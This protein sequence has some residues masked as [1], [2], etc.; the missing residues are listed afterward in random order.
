MAQLQ[1]FLYYFLLFN[2]FSII[3]ITDLQASNTNF[4]CLGMIWL[5]PSGI[6]PLYFNVS[7]FISVD[8][9][10]EGVLLRVN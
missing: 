5:N 6:W 3:E 2:C 8:G 7:I 9:S 4:T 10:A 1:N